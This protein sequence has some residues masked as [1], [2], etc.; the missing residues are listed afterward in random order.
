MQLP[1]G[2]L[3]IAP[4]ISI[5]LFRVLQESLTNVARHAGATQVRVVVS[6]SDTQ[7]QLEVQDNGK[8]I[9]PSAGDSQKTLGLLGMRERATIL[10]GS[11]TVDSAAGAG[12]AIVMTIPRRKA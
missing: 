10:G 9:G 1:D 8:G 11:F 7:L 12:T 3:N 4:D 6:E 5:A 2:E